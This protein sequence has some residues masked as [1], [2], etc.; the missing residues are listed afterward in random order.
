MYTV[1][2]MMALMSGQDKHAD[3]V[4]ISLR[5]FYSVKMYA[6]QNRDR[7]FKKTTPMVI[8]FYGIV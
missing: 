3:S 4:N 6:K 1:D 7:K 8:G 2:Q 5:L